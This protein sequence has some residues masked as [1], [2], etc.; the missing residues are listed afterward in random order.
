MVVEKMTLLDFID[1]SDSQPK[2]AKWIPIAKGEYG[3][4]AGDFRCS[5]CMKPNPCYRLTEFCANCGAV[6]NKTH[7]AHISEKMQNLPT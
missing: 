7:H 4:S 3:Y 1:D 5:N 2:R 6:M